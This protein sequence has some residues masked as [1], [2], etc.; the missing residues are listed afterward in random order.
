MDTNTQG[1]LPLKEGKKKFSLRGV[2]KEK[3]ITY[4]LW[5]MGLWL[6]GACIFTVATRAGGDSRETELN[7]SISKA[8]QEIVEMDTLIIQKKE[9]YASALLLKNE[10]E[11]KMNE[12]I[13]NMETQAKEA[14][15]LRSQIEQKN[16]ELDTYINEKAM[17]KMG[18]PKSQ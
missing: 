9:A 6:V 5:F 16:M 1:I 3:A 17:L 15:D 4:A 12:A 13:A 11:K 8:R 14:E 2:T 7:R 10:H 18:L